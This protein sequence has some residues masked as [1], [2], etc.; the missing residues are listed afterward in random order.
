MKQCF[1]KIVFFGGIFYIFIYKLFM[2][3]FVLYKITNTLLFLGFLK[4]AAYVNVFFLGILKIISDLCNCCYI[5]EGGPWPT[6]IG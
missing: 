5:F 3:N 2:F 4:I 1:G 6:G